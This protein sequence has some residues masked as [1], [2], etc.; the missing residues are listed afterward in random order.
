MAL[1]VL[2]IT[3]AV[4]SFDENKVTAPQFAKASNWTAEGFYA[5][6]TLF[7]AISSA[8]MFNQ[9]NWQRVCTSLALTLSLSL[10]L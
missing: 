6:V 9:A 1:L 3:V 4:I 10:F 5:L 7:I 8:E 2:I